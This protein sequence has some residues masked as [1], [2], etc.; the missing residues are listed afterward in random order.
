MTFCRPRKSITGSMVIMGTRQMT[1]PPPQ[2]MPISWMPRKSVAAIARNAPAVVSAPVTTP[3]PVKTIAL[4][5]ASSL[6]RPLRISSSYREMRCTPKSMA[7]P[8]R[9]GVKVTVRMFRCPMT[10]VVKAIV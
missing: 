6:L 7:I 5:S 10:A 4:R 2:I 8:T 3:M 1:S 9:I